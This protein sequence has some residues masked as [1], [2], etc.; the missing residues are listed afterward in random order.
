MIL[1]YVKNPMV[2][3][4][5]KRRRGITYTTTNGNYDPSVTGFLSY[6]FN[7][8]SCF[9]AAVASGGTYAGMDVP[10]PQFKATQAYKPTDL[11]CMTEVSGANDPTLC[12]GSGSNGITGDAAWLDGEWAA[13]SGYNSGTYAE[14]DHRLQT[15]WGK[16]NNRVNVLYVDGHIQTQYVSQLTWGEFWNVYG[17]P[18]ASGRGGAGGTVTPWPT[19]PTPQTWNG[20]IDYDTGM[21]SIVWC[22][23]GQ[24]E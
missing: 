3:V 12:D 13:Y 19:L 22:P 7:E 20:S 15:A 11:V 18:S 14:D 6:G 4:C 2:F 8:I 23:L 5:P 24:M 21:D 9:A 17:S 1:P 10:T 16:H